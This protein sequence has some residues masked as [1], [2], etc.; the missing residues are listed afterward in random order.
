MTN[1]I[2][3]VYPKDIKL[4]P[5]CNRYIKYF[6]SMEVGMS[7]ETK[8]RELAKQKDINFAMNTQ[9]FLTFRLAN[10]EYGIEI[11]KVREIIGLMKI[12]SVPRTPEYVR[13]VINLRGKVIPVMDLRVKF[14]MASI[15]DTAE[16]CIIVADVRRKDHSVQMGILVDSVSEV[17]DIKENEIE[18]AP[19][20]G[21][22]VDTDFINGMGKSKDKVIILLDINRVLSSEEIE[23]IEA[24]V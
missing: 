4:T 3:F 18:D 6:S 17:L 1:G 16:S 11:L 19:E 23:I 24:S 2:Y 21:N 10:E 15:E 5:C 9:K 13:G 7:V 20:F 14:N 22:Q 12:T 8:E